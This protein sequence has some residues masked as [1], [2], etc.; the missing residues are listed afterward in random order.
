MQL[1]FSGSKI[2]SKP[3]IVQDIIPYYQ[4]VRK[5]N[6]GDNCEIT[7]RINPD[8]EKK[9]ASEYRDTNGLRPNERKAT[10]FIGDDT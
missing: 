1:P 4:L 5:A 3:S 8:W 7:Y 9:F 10:F 6:M 2:N